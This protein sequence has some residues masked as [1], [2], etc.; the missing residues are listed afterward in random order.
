MSEPQH[1]KEILPEVM[2]N[3]EKRCEEY[4]M[5]NTPIKKPNEYRG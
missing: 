2:R 1:I 4:K 3:I 5:S